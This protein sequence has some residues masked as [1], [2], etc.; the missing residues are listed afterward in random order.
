MGFWN[1]VDNSIASA[2]ANRQVRAEAAEIKPGDTVYVTN[3]YR[4]ADGDKDYYTEVTV[5]R[6]GKIGS[7]TVEGLIRRNKDVT[8]TPPAGALPYA[9]DKNGNG[10]YTWK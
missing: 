3:T 4:T 1:M 2:K 7:D 6:K 5:D 10:G 9:P 8:T